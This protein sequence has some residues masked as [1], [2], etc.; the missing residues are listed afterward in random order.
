MGIS[1]ESSMIACAL[2][3]FPAFI[4]TANSFCDDSIQ[5]KWSSLESYSSIRIIL[6]NTLPTSFATC[7]LSFGSMQ[8]FP[9]KPRQAYF[10]K[11]RFYSLSQSG[12]P[13][14]EALCY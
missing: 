3:S 10:S 14:L 11:T 6:V 7:Y 9:T 2:S 8:R 13:F 5:S 4:I 12:F 1:F